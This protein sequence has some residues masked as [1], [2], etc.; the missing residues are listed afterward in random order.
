MNLFARARSENNTYEIYPRLYASTDAGRKKGQTHTAL[1][2]VT[3]TI[4]SD[5]VF[6]GRSLMILARNALRFPN[7]PDELTKSIETITKVALHFGISDITF[8]SLDYHHLNL[9]EWAAKEFHLRK[10]IKE[11]K[12]THKNV[13]GK[14][15]NMEED[16]D[17]DDT[18]EVDHDKDKQE[19]VNKLIKELEDNFGKSSAIQQMIRGGYSN[20]RICPNMILPSN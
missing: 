3:E 7:V 13:I 18:N 11:S 5:K 10:S 16:E 8:T 12:F 9:E 20:G 19:K 17:N 15:N 14:N 2:D 6:H 1:S 4:A